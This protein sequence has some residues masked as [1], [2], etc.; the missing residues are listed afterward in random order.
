[1]ARQLETEGKQVIGL[2]NNAGIG[3]PA[4]LEFISSERLRLQLDVN[5]FGHVR[6]LSVNA[7][8]GICLGDV[9]A[10]ESS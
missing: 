5:T 2:V 4:P 9:P 7:H 8:E 3:V 1:M 10:S 6:L